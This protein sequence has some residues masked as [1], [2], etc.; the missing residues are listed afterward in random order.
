MKDFINFE[1]KIPDIQ[2][3]TDNRHIPIKKVGVRNICRPMILL[4]Q[5][6]DDNQ[7]QQFT[8][9][10]WTLTVSLPAKDKGTHMSRFI[11]LLE[12]YQLKV[13][14]PAT[15]L[16]M[17]KEMLFFLNADK[18]DISTIFP[19]FI[20]KSAPVSGIKSL[21]DYKV[22]WNIHIENNQE[23]FE[24]IVKIPI[25]SLCPCSKAIADYGAHN[26]RSHVTISITL[27]ETLN[28]SKELSIYNIIRLVENE[29]SCELWS[30]LKRA[31][32]KYVTEYA[33]N[34]PKFVE[35]LVRDIAVRLNSINGISFYHIE[36]ENFES[37]HNHSAYAVIENKIEN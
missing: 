36:A 21:L 31:D 7:S 2:N 35:D 27:N 22:Q 19:Y 8:V 18:G 25:T 37:I 17:A 23:N 14:Q 30:L 12:R 34:N 15:L 13:M 33:Y 28:I 6:D 20:K 24:L 4:D 11:D 16:L 9:S 32:E 10:N 3:L 26:Q 5:T 1:P 29:A